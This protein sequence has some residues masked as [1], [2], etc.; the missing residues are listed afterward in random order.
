MSMHY[1]GV[2]PCQVTNKNFATMDQ[3]HNGYIGNKTFYV[4]LCLRVL[5]A[6]L[7]SISILHKEVIG[8]EQNAARTCKIVFCFFWV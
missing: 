8:D 5:V 7:T 1:Q 6:N 2:S 3:R 4:T